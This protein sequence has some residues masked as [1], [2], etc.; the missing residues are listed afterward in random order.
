MI[1]FLTMF[2]VALLEL[3]MPVSVYLRSYLNLK[4][5]FKWLY[6]NHQS[7]CSTNVRGVYYL[8]I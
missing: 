3:S 2:D 6:D 1:L 4:P 7:L 5:T 8:S